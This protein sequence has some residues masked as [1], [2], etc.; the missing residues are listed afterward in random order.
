MESTF[1]CRD[2][3]VEKAQ[4]KLESSL[5]WRQEVRPEKVHWDDI[6]FMAGQ[7]VHAIVLAAALCAPPHQPQLLPCK[8]QGGIRSTS[9]QPHPLFPWP[10][11]P[12]AACRDWKDGDPPEAPDGPEQQV[13]LLRQLAA[14]HQSAA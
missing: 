5:R 2:C 8:F 11:A 13:R 14:A 9:E 7:P 6:Q 3:D 4:I 1:A 12:L 10:S